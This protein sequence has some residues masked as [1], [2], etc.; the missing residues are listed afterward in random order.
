MMSN[1]DTDCNPADSDGFLPPTFRIRYHVTLALQG[2]MSQ[3]LKVAIALFLLPMK[4]FRGAGAYLVTERR[5]GLSWQA[6]AVGVSGFC[7]L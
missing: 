6:R 5:N 3:T 4:T 7:C 2:H 1:H